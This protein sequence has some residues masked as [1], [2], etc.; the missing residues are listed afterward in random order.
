VP[1][2]PMGARRTYKKRRVMGGPI[3][4]PLGA[5]RALIGGKMTPEGATLAGN[6]LLGTV[7]KPITD[8]LKP[9]TMIAQRSMP[10]DTSRPPMTFPPP[11][12]LY[13]HPAAVTKSAT[14]GPALPKG[15]KKGT[16]RGRGGARPV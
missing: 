3:L 11:A 9:A 6:S 10:K 16:G 8:R 4:P 15:Y 13:Q 2:K 14:P 5:A 1:D 12:P 7:A